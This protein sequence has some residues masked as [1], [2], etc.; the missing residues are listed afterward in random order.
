MHEMSIARSIIDLVLKEARK[1]KVTRINSVT[2]KIGELTAVVP[3]SLTFC[4]DILTK[5]SP[6]NGSELL[7]KEIPVRAECSDCAFEFTVKNYIFACPKCKSG[8]IAVLSGRELT[9][10]EMDVE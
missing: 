3:A 7:L 8:E 6:L 10:E 4:W 2:V 1:A 9:V 5:D